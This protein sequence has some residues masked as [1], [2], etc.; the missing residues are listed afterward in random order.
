MRADDPEIAPDLL[1]EVGAL[2]AGHGVPQ[3]EP[4]AAQREA[5]RR[6]VM[7]STHGY[8]GDPPPAGATDTGGQTLYV[9]QI[10]KECARAGREVVILARWFAPYAR[11]E[12]LEP[13]LWL[14]RIPAGG[15]RFVRK[16]DLYSLVPE[17]AEYATAVAARFGADAV[18]G[19][20]AD[21]M[22]VAA[23]IATRLGLPFVAMPHSLARTKIA[24]L[25]RDPDD[26]AAWF[27]EQYRFA[28]REEYEVAA[29]AQADAVIGCLPDQLDLLPRV[30]R[31]RTPRQV[32]TP[33]VA[34]VFFETADE[35]LDPSIRDRF[36]LVPGQFLIVTARLAQTKNI[37]GAVALLGEARALA[38]ARFGRVVLAVVG[39]NPEPR[40]PE[41]HAVEDSI[42]AA[43]ARHG[44]HRDDVRRIPAQ[45]W[46]V[47]AQL[48]H[49]SLFYVGMQHFEPFGMGAAEALAAGVPVLLSR[50]AGI[51]RALEGTRTEPPCAVL[52]D[53]ADPRAAARRLIEALDAP[54][55][56][57]RMTEAGQ[58]LARRTLSWPNGAA[59]LVAMLDDLA[60]RGPPARP[61]HLRGCHRLASAWRGDRPRIAT[62]HAWSAEQ[63]V[64]RIVEAQRVAARSHRR[65]IV[66]IGGESGAGK[67]E[68]A[69]CLGIALR[70][71]RLGS[72]VL[73][74]DVF[75]RRPPRANHEA[76]LAA[77][78]AGR[79]A[80]YI[81]PPHEIDLEA[82]D[83]VLEQAADQRTQAIACPSDCRALP[84][85]RYPRVPL[86][87]SRCE[88]VLVD[89]TYA[90]LLG[91]A[92]LRIFLESDYRER[93][94]YIL[95]RNTVRD[96]DQ[97]FSFITKVLAI[98]H[99]QIQRTAVLAQLRVDLTGAVRDAGDPAAAR[100]AAGAQD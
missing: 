23:E 14:V 35:R 84:G 59:R 62:Q 96:P 26:L 30:Y 25:G 17:L 31:L 46:P 38:P 3:V 8:W 65:L 44:L 95:R 66:A 69:H 93:C 16:E 11:V 78:R 33:G 2:L 81:G 34:P 48:L 88:I 68:I 60:T 54:A 42:A 32:I 24:G 22:T 1:D 61:G 67:T 57:S 90:M 21:G 100:R 43:M 89:L 92:A 7:V 28:T 86:D 99:E 98:E 37:A 27:D 64:P 77:D 29:I 9:L 5:C 50:C 94:E 15:D 13:R 70:R 52:V 73:P 39:G 82:L 72:A 80:D 45:P 20:Y 55:E 41:E 75:F 97:D 40:E 36:A 58:R 12:Q 85:R 83:R 4:G 18:M 91:V 19:H 76:R 63:L 49:Q 10:S 71:H 6:I 51:A 87:L 74:G 47:I 56:L 79:L 53:P